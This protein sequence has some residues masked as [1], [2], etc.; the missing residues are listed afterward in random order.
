MRLPSQ[1]EILK[2]QE[3]FIR[4]LPDRPA[5]SISEEE[6]EEFEDRLLIYELQAA[7]RSAITASGKT[8]VIFSL[9]LL[10]VVMLKILKVEYAIVLFGP[11]ILLSIISCCRIFDYQKTIKQLKK[12]HNIPD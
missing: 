1:Q 8:T 11:A 6:L 9:L 3:A 12:K 5:G 4:S 7:S 10:V 2:E